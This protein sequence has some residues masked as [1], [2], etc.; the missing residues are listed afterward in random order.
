MKTFKW[1][2]NPVVTIN[3]VTVPASDQVEGAVVNLQVT[4]NDAKG[5]PLTFSVPATGTGSLPPGLSMNSA[6]LITG[7]IAAGASTGSPYSV[8]VTATD[9][10]GFSGKETFQWVVTA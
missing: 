1:T 5:L 8:T 6:G 9:S 3:T 7:T 10:A 4:G 2:V